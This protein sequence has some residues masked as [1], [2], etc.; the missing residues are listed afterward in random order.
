M[1]GV[2]RT[3]FD[4]HLAMRHIV[5][6]GITYCTFEKMSDKKHLERRSL[7]ECV[8]GE[9]SSISTY[10]PTKPFPRYI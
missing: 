6:N 8:N 1:F 7:F 10:T 2:R 4:I 5:V 3:I 9:A